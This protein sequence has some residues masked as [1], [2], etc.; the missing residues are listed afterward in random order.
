MITSL[1]LI[2]GASGIG[3]LWQAVTGNS[4]MDEVRAAL[5][6]EVAQSSDDVQSDLQA[7]AAAGTIG[8]TLTGGSS[9]QPTGGGGSFGGGGGSTSWD[10]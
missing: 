10:G 4:L 5:G 3:L 2:V 6:L 1:G 9:S 8:K 7:G